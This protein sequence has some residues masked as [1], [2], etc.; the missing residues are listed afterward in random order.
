MRN[1]ARTQFFAVFQ[2]EVLLN[3][4]RI[5]PYLLMVF[6]VC[7]AVLWS[8]GL[9]ATYYGKEV[10]A[11]YGRLWAANSDYG[12]CLSLA[13][14]LF[15]RKSTRGIGMDGHLTERGWSILLA[16]VSLTTAIG[17]G[18]IIWSRH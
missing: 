9:G 8:A 3:S 12:A 10:P 18:W 13:H 5:V 16:L 11:K 4:K 17:T 6:S 1:P 15:Q 14:I 2:N 7:N